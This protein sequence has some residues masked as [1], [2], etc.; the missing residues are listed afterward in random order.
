ME[1]P[2]IYNAVLLIFLYTEDVTCGLSMDFTEHF[3]S[4]RS[5]RIRLLVLV[6]TPVGAA[7]LFGLARAWYA[8]TLAEEHVSWLGALDLWVLA[9]LLAGWVLGLGLAWWGCNRY[10]ILPL[11]TLEAAVMA[12]EASHHQ[13]G[14]DLHISEERLRL[15]LKAAN[16]GLYDLNVQT[17]ATVVSPEYAHMLGYA[18]DDFVETNTAWRERL[19]PD[20]REPVYQ[21]YQDYIAG[22]RMEYRIE[23]R[24]RT[25]GG[26]WKWILSLGRIVTWDDAGQPLRMLGTH[27]DITYR[28]A[29]EETLQ[30]S[31]ARYRELFQVNPNPMWIYD[32]ETLAFLDVNETAVARYGYSRQE[33][34][35]MTLKDIRP[36][37]DIPRMLED[38]A[39]TENE[40]NE[41][42]L[43]RHVKKDGQVIF[44][45]IRSHTIDF[46]GR[47]AR[48]VLSHDVT[49]QLAAEAEI[50]RL[51]AELE[52]RVEQRTAQLT[53]ANQEL[54][55]F[56]YSVS[57][58][59]RAPLRAI[60][61]FSRILAEEYAG[62]L[63]EEGLRLLA[64]IRDNTERMDRLISDLLELARLSRSTLEINR[65]D[66][67]A[68]ASAA[69]QELTGVGGS[70]SFHFEL[71]PLPEACGDAR[72]LRQVWNNLFGNAIKY[73]LPSD[74]RR[75]TVSGQAASA[76]LV[77]CVRDRGVGFNP[78]YA[79]KIFGLFQRLHKAEEFEGTGLG[80][81]IVERIIMRH[82]GRVWAEGRP[83]EGAAFYFTLPIRECDDGPAT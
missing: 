27:T 53:A 39:S 66:M 79:H 38:V 54:E 71:S 35:S 74:E 58:D 36:A 47:P 65:V 31:E 28:K 17:G 68:L 78:D 50:L 37:E 61:G 76:E 41:A 21:A 18:P 19:H 42:G 75:I 64:V 23:F 24:Q 7:A 83:G 44:V 43:W 49:E 29:A 73:S 8:S 60:D 9:G 1:S 34:L 56:S 63:D 6:S 70:E 46:D 32:L 59:L 5:I 14:Q 3:P 82:G 33:F 80:L 15:A 13:A 51:N 77:F 30:R 72:Q 26:S 16:Q 40:L 55:A 48:L 12:S 4:H 10:L 62:V 22:R 45:E 57:H 25:R 2:Q 81:A 20:D 52:Q 11:E 69:F 67:H